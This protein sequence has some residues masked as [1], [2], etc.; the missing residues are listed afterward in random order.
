MD[1]YS[2]G[3]KQFETQFWKTKDKVQSLGLF[4]ST[5]Y[6]FQAGLVE[7]LVSG[8]IAKQQ[9]IDQV[10]IDIGSCFGCDL[11][12]CV[13]LIWKLSLVYQENGVSRRKEEALDRINQ[14]LKAF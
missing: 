1:P 10:D 11:V 9:Y 13:I 3:P 7:K 5:I 2:I 8:K 12:G 4:A 6:P 14:I